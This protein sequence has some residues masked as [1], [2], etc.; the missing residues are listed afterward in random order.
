M[1]K[2]LL[3]RTY[4][5]INDDNEYEFLGGWVFRRVSFTLDAWSETLNPPLLGLNV[6]L[7]DFS[8]SQQ[9]CAKHEKSNF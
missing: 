7:L 5:L 6:T 2:V 3:D 4:A 8:P 9:L 1:I